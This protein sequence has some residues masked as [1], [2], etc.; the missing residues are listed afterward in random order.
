MRLGG[1]V[2]LDVL[3]KV[4]A[5]LGSTPIESKCQ[6]A[7]K[8]EE[9]YRLEHSMIFR[10]AGYAW[11]PPNPMDIG[12]GFQFKTAGLSRRSIECLHFLSK[13]FPPSNRIEWYDANVGLSASLSFKIDTPLKDEDLKNPWRS[14]CQTIVGSS[15][16]VVRIN[17]PDVKVLR[18]LEPFE[19]LALIGWCASFYSV[20]HPMPNVQ[21]ASSL[22]GNAFSG[23]AMYPLLT[24]MMAIV[25]HARTVSAGIAEHPSDD[26]D[27]EAADGSSD[28]S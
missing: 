6:K 18:L 7:A 3:A 25:G 9:K 12:E 22:A 5:A 17:T 13:R 16:M 20:G 4:K 26:S 23:F 21:L 27:G 10:A 28:A 15:Q 14:F 11:P 19:C 8:T 2:D 24:S 1:L